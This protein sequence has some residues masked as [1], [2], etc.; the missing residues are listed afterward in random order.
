MKF[1]SIEL[2]PVY[3]A[4]RDFYPN[5]SDAPALPERDDPAYIQYRESYRGILKSV[6][7]TSGIY[8]W[9]AVREA[10][11]PEYVYLGESHGNKNGLR[12]RLDDEFKRIYHGFWA[13]VFNT[14]KYLDETIR[15][16]GNRER[17]RPSKSYERHI[18]NDYQRRGATHIVFGSQI[19]DNHNL[20]SIQN[21]LIQM[22]ENPR[23][24]IKDV[25]S[26]PL[27]Q[28]QL[29]QE[30]KTI[31]DGFKGIIQSSKFASQ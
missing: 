20:V 31:F 9:F 25:R 16:F 10:L 28:A 7:Q 1:D 2:Q 8:L 4:I 24:N 13:T 22:F 15:V 19:P 3:R 12:G 11:S 6:P 21:D 27:S 29:S 5:G 30:A 14:E 17:Y 18:R 26:F 23:G